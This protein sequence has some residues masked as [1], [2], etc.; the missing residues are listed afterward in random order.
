MLTTL[1]LEQSEH[2]RGLTSQREDSTENREFADMTPQAFSMND[3][4]GDCDKPLRQRMFQ[5]HVELFRIA[6]Q[7]GK[8]D[9]TLDPSANASFCEV[10]RSPTV[11]KLYCWIVKLSEEL[12][13]PMTE[14]APGLVKYGLAPTYSKLQKAAARI[15]MITGSDEQE[16]NLLE[17]A[18]F[19]KSRGFSPRWKPNLG[20]VINLS[21][22]EDFEVDAEF[23]RCLLGKPSCSN[24]EG[25]GGDAR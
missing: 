9:L 23:S 24:A 10:C 18:R 15:S 17:Y 6:N 2:K 11:R 22:I 8:E 7:K 19:L 1:N 4:Q 20:G 13:Q 21:M 16:D 25:Y 12:D 14:I 5:L 3:Q